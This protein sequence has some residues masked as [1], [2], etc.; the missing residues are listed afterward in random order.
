MSHIAVGIARMDDQRQTRLAR[1]GDMGAKTLRL[2]IARRMIVEI[3]EP[4]LADRHHFGMSGQPDKVLDSHVQLFSGVV[5]MGA[6]RAID[7]VERFRYLKDLLEPLHTR[8][9]RHHASDSS[10]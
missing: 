2:R 5:R 4:G 9:D 10:G 8:R 1:C 6:D 7:F 3:V